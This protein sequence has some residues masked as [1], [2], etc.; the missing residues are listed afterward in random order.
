L[1]KEGVDAI[2]SRND[3][4]LKLFWIEKDLRER[5]ARYA[6]GAGKGGLYSIMLKELNELM[7]KH[8]T[9]LPYGGLPED[10]NEKDG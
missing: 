5:I 9:K 1:G 2:N 3:F 8:F 10:E 6:S 4:Q 7:N